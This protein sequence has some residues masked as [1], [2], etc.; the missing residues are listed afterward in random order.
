M[1]DSGCF[2]PW[3]VVLAQGDRKAVFTGKESSALTK[4]QTA[5]CALHAALGWEHPRERDP[6]TGQVFWAP[7]T[8]IYP[9]EVADL[10]D[11]IKTGHTNLIPDDLAG[12]CGDIAILTS[13]WESNTELKLTSCEEGLATDPIV[14]S[15]ISFAQNPALGPHTYILEDGPWLIAV[16]GPHADEGGEILEGMYTHKAAQVSRIHAYVEDLEGQEA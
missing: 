16:S 11:M 4:I 9:M 10:M 2:N 15:W 5:I 13:A 7:R 1:T 8:I 3:A 12:V 14:A 6:D